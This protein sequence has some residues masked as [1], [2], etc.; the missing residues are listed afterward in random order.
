[1]VPNDYPTIS[2]AIRNA[3]QGDTIYVKNG[4]YYENPVI[5]KSISIVGEDSENTIV[6]GSGGAPGITFSQ[7]KQIML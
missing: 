7:L 1:M 2:D 5:D 6:I 3:S 4:V